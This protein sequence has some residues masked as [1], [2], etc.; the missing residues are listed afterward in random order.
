MHYQFTNGLTYLHLTGISYHSVFCFSQGIEQLNRVLKR[1][2]SSVCYMTSKHFKL[3]LSVFM[4]GQNYLRLQRWARI[5][6][7]PVEDL[8]V[9]PLL[10]EFSYKMAHAKR[11]GSHSELGIVHCPINSW[12]YSKMIAIFN[13]V[14]IWQTNFIFSSTFR[15]C[16]LSFCLAW[17]LDDCGGCSLQLTW[18]FSELCKFFLKGTDHSKILKIILDN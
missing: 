13:I 15:H 4:A 12:Q 1:L 8:L 14:W 18:D 11:L 3:T 2:A 6:E 16:L 10:L 17:A 5:G 7:A 9:D